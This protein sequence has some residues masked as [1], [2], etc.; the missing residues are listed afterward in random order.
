LEEDLIRRAASILVS[1]VVIRALAAPT[2]ALADAS[3]S[4]AA[5]TPAP[6]GTYLAGQVVAAPEAPLI[7]DACSF[8]IQDDSASPLP[9][10]ESQPL[11]TL[12]VNLKIHNPSPLKSVRDA[13]VGF[14]ILDGS[15]KPIAAWNTTFEGID[16][17]DKTGRIF[18][19]HH[20]RNFQPATMS[21]E[22]LHVD[23][24]DNTWWQNHS[25]N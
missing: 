18:S 1:A 19:L 22:L 15:N 5:A 7:V 25:P 6:E 23:F 9:T 2:P 17:V 20:L 4:P 11:R 10:L 14:S 21:C 3:P 24:D 12:S 16:A 8:L 13:T